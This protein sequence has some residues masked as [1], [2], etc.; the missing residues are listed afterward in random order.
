MAIPT[1]CMNRTSLMGIALAAAFAARAG[2]VPEIS[3]S[4][5]GSLRTPA[6]AIEKVRALR[7]EGRIPAGRVAVVRFAPGTYELAGELEVTAADAP[8]EFIGA[9]DCKTVFSGGRRLGPFKSGTDGIW[10]CKVPEGFVFEQLWVNGRR[11]QIARHPNKFYNYVLN[12]AGE[13]IDP[14]TG[15]EA[16]LRRRGFYTDPAGIACLAGIPKDELVEASI[17]VWWAWDDE[18]QRPVHVDVAKGYVVLKHPVGRDFF[19]W[20]KWCPRF[21]IE[22]CR[23]ALDAPGEWFLDRKCGELLYIPREGDKIDDTVAV[24]PVLGRIVFVHDTKGV[25]FRDISFEH[26]G[27]LMGKGHFAHQSAFISTSAL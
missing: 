12:S 23:T 25:S 18:W 1:T 17:H 11:A 27:W 13:D 15:K 2:T 9:K 22:N 7:A 16:D 14:V 8:I 24:A 26:N 20:P 4:P 10:R 21:N 3:V 19:M 5:D 6:A